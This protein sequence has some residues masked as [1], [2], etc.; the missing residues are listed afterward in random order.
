MSRKIDLTKPLSDA[1]RAHLEA[2]DRQDLLQ[3]NADILAQ[4]KE[5]T[6][7]VDP[8]EGPEVRDARGGRDPEPPRTAPGE[9][10]SSVSNEPVAQDDE[11]GDLT[12][13]ELRE[14]L[15]EKG[16]SQSGNK[17]DLIAR[18]RASE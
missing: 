5:P 12:N 6:K 11:Y 9:A 3:R 16:L 15:D 2:Y 1:D 10:V 18:L 14:R 17:A 4:E 8:G 7:A 13:D